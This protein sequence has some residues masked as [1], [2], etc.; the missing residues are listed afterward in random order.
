[1]IAASR[2]AFVLLVGLIWCASLGAA[3]SQ[4]Y[5]PPAPMQEWLKS[6]EKQARRLV[7]I[8]SC[9]I[10]ARCKPALPDGSTRRPDCSHGRCESRLPETRNADPGES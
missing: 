3:R 8:N 2:C 9:R 10:P 6:T 1:M 4:D 5:Q 7:V